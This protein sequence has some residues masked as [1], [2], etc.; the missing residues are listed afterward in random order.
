MVEKTFLI[1]EAVFGE[2]SHSRSCLPPLWID[3]KYAALREF[4]HL[5]KIYQ[6]RIFE[7]AD[8]CG[9]LSPKFALKT[10]HFVDVFFELADICPNAD[11]LLVNP[12]PQLESLSFNV[13][14][15]GEALHPGITQAAQE[16]ISGAGIN[17]DISDIGRMRGNV[18]CYCNFWAASPRFWDAYFSRWMAPVWEHSLSLM[19]AGKPHLAF[20]PTYHVTGSNVLFP[21]IIERLFSTFLVCTAGEFVVQS[22]QFHYGEILERYCL[23]DV[24]CGLWRQANAAVT[25]DSDLAVNKS[26]FSDFTRHYAENIKSNYS[27]ETHPHGSESWT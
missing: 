11:V 20:Q 26:M 5:S 6:E 24:E 10:H 16:L 15:Q 17:V 13:W 8:Y 22:K 18:L 23:D 7:E 1:Y 12:F 25:A 27:E 9:V 14:T 4:Q 19:K 2:F 21:F 3:N